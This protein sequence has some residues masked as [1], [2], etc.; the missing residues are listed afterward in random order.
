MTRTEIQDKIIEDLPLKPHGLLKFAPR[1]GKSR[2]I[3]ETIKKNKPKKILWVTVST[4]LRDV[5]IP[6]EIQRWIGKRYLNKTDIV[7]Y[8]SLGNLEGQ[9]DMIV[10]DK[11]FVQLKPI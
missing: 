1:V 3:C 2:I 7:C 6:K 11:I 10:L 8:Q 5:D 9:Y 4:E